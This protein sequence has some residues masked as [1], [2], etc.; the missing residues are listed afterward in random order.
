MPADHGLDTECFFIAPIG[1]PNTEVRKRSDAIE[2][3]VV[4]RAAQE[5][6]LTVQRAD[7]IDQP[8]QLTRQLIDHVI[9]ARAAVVDLTGSNPNVYYEMA[10]RHTL[11]KP[12]VLIA[13]TGEQLPFDI[14]Q[15]RVIFFDYPDLDEAAR[16]SNL[17]L[18]YLRSALEGSVDSLVASSVA[19]AEMRHGDAEQRTLATLVQ[20]VETLASQMRVREDLD[21]IRLVRVT[22]P[23]QP[24]TVRDLRD[25][26]DQLAEYA[27]TA[28]WQRSNARL[29]SLIQALRTKLDELGDPDF[30]TS[31]GSAVNGRPAAPDIDEVAAD[32]RWEKAWRVL[33]TKPDPEGTSAG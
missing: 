23:A 6:G 18:K 3:Y 15:M 32:A 31:G 11:R 1:E 21:Q 8:G 16:C 25:Q 20:Q 14:A 2:Q 4:G 24:E 22:I 19:V 30:S 17:L 7:R 26:L 33:G 13:Q 27:A 29:E 10:V 28:T 9:G 5:L 12:T